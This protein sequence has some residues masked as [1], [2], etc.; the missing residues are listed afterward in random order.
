M[1]IVYDSIVI[2]ITNRSNKNL[3]QVLYLKLY[4]YVAGR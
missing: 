1:F 3:I 4:D 2:I